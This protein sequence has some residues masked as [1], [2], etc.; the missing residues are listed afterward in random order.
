MRKI[1]TVLLLIAVC[2]GGIVSA[3]NNTTAIK[4]KLENY[5]KNYKPQGAQFSKTAHLTD[6]EMDDEEETL[7]VTANE[8][9]AEQGFT[10]AVVENIYQRIKELPLRQVFPESDDPQ[11]RV[12]GTDSQ[13]SQ[14]T[15]G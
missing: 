8:A 14:E 6:L 7:V 15:Q 1:I 3:Q 9:F 11:L 4:A 12:A 13:P 2:H 10:P 5:F